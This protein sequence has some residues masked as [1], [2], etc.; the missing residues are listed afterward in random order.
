MKRLWVFLVL[1]SWPGSLALGETIVVTP[2][3]SLTIQQAIDQ[4]AVGDTVALLDGTYQ[5]D[6]NRDLDYRGK[7]IFLRSQSGDP[8]ACI[9]DCQGTVLEHHRGFLFESGEGLDSVLEGITVTGGNAYWSGGVYCQ[10]GFPTITG[11]RFIDNVGTEGGGVSA[12]GPVVVTDCLFQGNEAIN[13]GGMSAA[14]SVGEVST[15]VRCTF[16]GNS[17]SD[18]GGGFRA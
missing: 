4:A 3:G 12:C 1:V 10:G 2:F 7:A 18:Y 11:C 9:I 14:C 17:A 16:V 5:G 6:G 15:V 13:G 8:A